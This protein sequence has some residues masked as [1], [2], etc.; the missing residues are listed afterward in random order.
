MTGLAVLPQEVS[1][2]TG[3]SGSGEPD[4]NREGEQYSDENQR[5]GHDVTVVA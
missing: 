1:E 5:T 4:D 3:E 2:E